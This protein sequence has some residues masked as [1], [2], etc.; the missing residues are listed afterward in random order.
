MGKDL[1]KKWDQKWFFIIILAKVSQ[2]FAYVS[3][4]NEESEY[5]SS[6]RKILCVC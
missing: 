2:L 4:I 6:S 1:I 3:S 5:R